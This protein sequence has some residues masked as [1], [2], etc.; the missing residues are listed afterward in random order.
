MHC[1]KWS[2]IQWGTTLKLSFRDKYLKLR[3]YLV[4]CT[5]WDIFQGF[6]FI[7][8]FRYLKNARAVF[9]FENCI[10][11]ENTWNLKRK[12]CLLKVPLFLLKS[13]RG[14][15]YKAKKR[16]LPRIFWV[17]KKVCPKLFLSKKNMSNEILG[18]IKSWSENILSTK[19]FVSKEIFLPTNFLVQ[20]IFWLKKMLIKK[21]LGPNKC[22]SKSTSRMIIF[23]PDYWLQ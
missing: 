11:S 10:K 2:L 7:N 23:V 20:K 5:I 4:N 12:V 6:L 13:A 18:P 8:V 3:S 15:S 19:K 9:M 21:M 17:P 1:L 22:L 14:T 16:M